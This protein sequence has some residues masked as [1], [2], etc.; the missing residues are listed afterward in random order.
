MKV[1]RSKCFLYCIQL[2]APLE[3]P[4]SGSDLRLR[5]V[6]CYQCFSRVLFLVTFLN[7]VYSIL[8]FFLS[9]FSLGTFHLLPLCQTVLWF[10]FE[11]SWLHAETKHTALLLFF[12]SVSIE[13][14]IYW[15]NAKSKIHFLKTSPSFNSNFIVWKKFSLSM[16]YKFEK[17]SITSN[18]K[19]R[20]ND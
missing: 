10:S 2:L 5:I 1:V 11:F 13:F 15:H 20:S 16:N 7:T 3:I 8:I 17:W 9:F 18:H 4:D 19:R 14:R 12:I 6:H